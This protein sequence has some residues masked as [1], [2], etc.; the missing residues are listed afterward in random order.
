MVGFLQGQK[1]SG[2]K[3]WNIGGNEVGMGWVHCGVV[4]AMRL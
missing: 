4:A 3:L 2:K 1:T